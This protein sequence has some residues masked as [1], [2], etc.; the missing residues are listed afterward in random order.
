MPLRPPELSCKRKKNPCVRAPAPSFKNVL[1]PVCPTGR[2]VFYLWTVCVC[3]LRAGQ[4]ITKA[5]P[6]ASYVLVVPITKYAHKKH[7]KEK[8]DKNA[9]FLLVTK[10]TKFQCKDWTKRI[11][12]KVQAHKSMWCPIK[13]HLVTFFMKVSCS[14]DDRELQK[15]RSIANHL[16]RYKKK[17]SACMLL[18]KPSKTPNK[19]NTDIVVKLLKGRM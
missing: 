4:E 6:Q 3:W 15:Y 1:L 5:S 11:G 7:K 12:D 16:Y 17:V 18:S 10:L 9:R 19:T 2:I 13:E 14:F 8:T